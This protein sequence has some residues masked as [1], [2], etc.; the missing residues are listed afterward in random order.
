VAY[1]VWPL[2]WP[3][4]VVEKIIVKHQVR[5]EEVEEVLFDQRGSLVLRR[6]RG[7]TFYAVGKTTAGRKLFVV[8]V[9]AT[10]PGKYTVVTAREFER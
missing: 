5:P 4:N 1:F 2:I 6:G 10:G 3:D 9:K 7:G 8:L